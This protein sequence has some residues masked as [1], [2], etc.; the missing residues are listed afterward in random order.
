MKTY[1][2]IQ[3][4]IQK[5]QHEAEIMKNKEISLVISDIKEK[6]SLYNLT[7]KDIGL[8]EKN[9]GHKNF[10]VN[11]KIIPIKFRDDKG[12]QWSGRGK[13]P[14][15]LTKALSEGKVLEDFLVRN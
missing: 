3:A 11:K 4:E 15:W 12:N 6:I 2:E 13:Q 10:Q 5:L 14:R 8:K 1:S 7:P 9:L